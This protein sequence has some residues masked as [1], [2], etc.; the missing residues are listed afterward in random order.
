M[1]KKEGSSVELAKVEAKLKLLQE[2]LAAA[3]SVPPQQ[4]DV[5]L[6]KDLKRQVG[7][8][9]ASKAKIIKDEEERQAA[10]QQREAAELA[11]RPPIA[12][13]SRRLLR[14]TWA[15]GSSTR[16]SSS[17][18]PCTRAHASPTSYAERVY[19]GRGGGDVDPVQVL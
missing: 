6:I 9:E 13:A 1:A 18:S 2:R 7:E 16:A 11:R 8:A 12:R 3:K 4:R 15:P 10:K 5:P 17:W 19:F 14:Y